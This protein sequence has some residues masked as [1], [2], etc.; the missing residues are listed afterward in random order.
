M[1]ITTYKVGDIAPYKNTRGNVRNAEITSFEI[2]DNGKA[3][4]RGIDT[5]TKTKVWYPVHISEGLNKSSFDK[6]KLL[7]D[8]VAGYEVETPKYKGVVCGFTYEYN[9]NYSER[10]IIAVIEERNGWRGIRYSQHGDVCVTHKQNP[11]GYDYV[12][13]DELEVI[14]NQQIDHDKQSGK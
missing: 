8:T 2:V 10:F 11:K 13:L 4:F 12:F 14:L 3:W 5:A 1:K 9:D 7:Y 6:M